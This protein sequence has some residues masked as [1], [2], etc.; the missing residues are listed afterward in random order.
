MFLCEQQEERWKEADTY[1]AS[2]RFWLRDVIYHSLDIYQKDDAESKID[3]QDMCG[4]KHTLGG[5]INCRAQNSSSKI[6]ELKHNLMHMCTTSS[7][8]RLFHQF[9]MSARSGSTPYHN[10]LSNNISS[11]RTS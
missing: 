9:L 5:P 11:D 8:S 6:A 4:S 2:T 7:A 3:F 1:T 10:A